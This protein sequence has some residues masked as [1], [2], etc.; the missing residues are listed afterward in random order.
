LP[1]A[2]ILRGLYQLPQSNAE[3]N[4]YVSLQYHQKG[5]SNPSAKAVFDFLL[6]ELNQIA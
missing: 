5:M 1:E 4:F 6:K 3:T 2:E